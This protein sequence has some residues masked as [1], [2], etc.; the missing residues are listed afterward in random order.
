MA[1]READKEAM[2]SYGEAV[3]KRVGEKGISDQDFD[4]GKQEG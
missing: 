4:V 2:G 1:S 3:G